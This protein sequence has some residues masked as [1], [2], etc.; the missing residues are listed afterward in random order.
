MPKTYGLPY[1]GSKNRIAN[2]IINLLPPAETFVDLFAGGCAMTHAAILS[3]KYQKFIINDI[4][5]LPIQLFID[6]IDGKYL[7]SFKWYSRDEFNQLKTTDGFVKYCYSFGSNG[8]DYLYSKTKEP[9]KK[10]LFDAVVYGDYNG[11]EKYD[12]DLTL[13]D[14]TIQQRMSYLNKY[15]KDSELRTIPRIKRINQLI[16]LA[17]YKDKITFYNKDYR[18]V[19]IPENSVIYCDIP[20]TNTHGYNNTDFNRDE[21]LYNAAGVPNLYISEYNLTDDRFTCIWEKERTSSYS[22]QNNGLKVTE[23][24][25]KTK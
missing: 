22:A 20:Y 3:G 19:E 10:A 8:V 7:D 2:D 24:L 25:Y 9:Y 1:M 16:E 6:G 14:G 13:P 12:I 5:E 4:D 15:V 23:R 21:F 17:P 11:F 18:S